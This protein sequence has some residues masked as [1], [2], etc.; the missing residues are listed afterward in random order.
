MKKL[1]FLTI[2]L[3]YTFVN[4]GQSPIELE[5]FASG[6]DGPVALENAGDDR[7]FVVEQDGVIRVRQSD[8]TVSTFLDISGP[9]NSNSNERG[10][11]GLAFHPDYAQNGEFYVNYTRSGGATRIS[12]FNV[13]SDENIA[14]ENS[15]E[16]ILEIDQPYNNHNGGD[17]QFGPD[18]Y[19]YIGMGDG[20]SA[21]DPDNF[22]Q[23]TQSLLGK[24]LRIDIDGASP[25]EVPSNNPFISDGNV[26][27]EIWAIGLRNP[28]RYSFDAETGD[29]WIG[30][31]GQTNLEE[32]D[33]QPSSSAGG[34]N[35]GWRCYEGNNPFNT[36][37]CGPASDF[38]DA[39]FEYSHAGGN[40][41]VTGGFVY[42][43][44]M[45]P[46][47][48]GNYFCVDYC[49]GN[50]WSVYMNAGVW[51]SEMVLQAGQFGWST[52]GQDVNNELFV[53]NQDGNIYRIV[54]ACAGFSPT[55]TVNGDVLSAPAGSD[56]QWFLNGQIIPGANGQTYTITETGD[57]SLAMTSTNGC[58]GISEPVNVILTSIGAIEILSELNYFPNPAKSELN[59]QFQAFET[60]T[61]N[62]QL[63]SA[64]GQVV[65]EKSLITQ[66]GLN[67]VLF[68]LT[69]I[70]T[71]IYIVNILS[72]KQI[73]SFEIVK[74]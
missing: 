4:Y 32:I 10:L 5:L 68:D 18:G 8:G 61:V 35:Y 26:L 11:L 42:R 53:V 37:G 63:I 52:F 2:A 71:G 50:F 13:S 1:L 38:V 36:V 28:W 7:M 29:L 21:N 49:S 44:S 59:I 57:Y 60:A 20:G 64:L 27:D 51:E 3:A 16:V 6:F 33:F 74:H 48:V 14:D 56:Y 30:D 45:Q 73:L 46:E 58:S 66:S 55:F 43:G 23:N 12:R 22:A 65:S 54:D 19:L 40:C 41:S 39:V 17:I 72:D 62:V 31:V 24:M 34:E 67:Q 69:K 70:E 9:V 25:Y 47:L 15:E